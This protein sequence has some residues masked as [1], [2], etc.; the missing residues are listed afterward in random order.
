MFWMSLAIADPGCADRSTPRE[1]DA[2]LESAERDL[3]ELD[4]DG[5][6]EQTADLPRVLSCLEDPLTSRQAARVHRAFGL[7]A[8]LG[9][10]EA[11]A[12]EAF[13]AARH[14]DPDY[15]FPFWLV[16]ERHAIR[17]LYA[18]ATPTEAVLPVLPARAGELRFDGAPIDERPQLRPVVVQVLD[19]DGKVA[20]TGWLRPTDPL[21]PYEPTHP[22]LPPLIGP[23]RTV[24][25]GLLVT[26]GLST[27]VA[28]GAYGWAGLANRDFQKA[29][30]RDSL[31]GSQRRANTLVTTSAIAGG[32]AVVSLTGAFLVG[33]F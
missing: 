16:P 21:P 13:A 26:A 25:T 30:D 11:G 24:R 31:F 5:F 20:A 10:Q 9:R 29:A 1:L 19:A 22:V 18:D 2:L 3:G 15:V 6:L 23:S 32:T 17:Q 28:G 7:R 14:A 27:L 8:F 12:R 33:R 4:S